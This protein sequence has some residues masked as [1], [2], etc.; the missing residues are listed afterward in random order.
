MRH[1]FVGF[2][3]LHVPTVELL[4]RELAG[5]LFV[6]MSIGCLGELVGGEDDVDVVELSGTFA[7]HGIFVDV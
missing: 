7:G 6:L 5:E 3:V 2:E 1:V 4:K